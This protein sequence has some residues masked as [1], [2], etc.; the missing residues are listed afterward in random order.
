MTLRT[1]KPASHAT[2]I[3]RAKPMTSRGRAGSP[4][5]AAAC[6]P[7]SRIRHDGAHGVTRPTYGRHSYVLW[8]ERNFMQAC[9]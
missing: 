1:K 4:L 8:A 5:P 7:R 3:N 6:N 9:L 2:R